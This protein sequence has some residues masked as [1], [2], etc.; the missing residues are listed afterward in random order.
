MQTVLQQRVDLIVFCGGDGTA[1]D[2]ATV[3]DKKIPLLGIPSGVKMHSGVFGVN[4]EAAGKMI[5]RFLSETVSVGD[6]EIMDLDE[7]LYRKGTWMVRLFHTVKGLIEPSFVQVG[8]MSFATVSEE[9]IKDDIAE[10]IKDELDDQPQTLFLFGSG[11]TID[12]IARFLGLENTVLGIDAVCNHQLVAKDM[13]EEK[14]LSL[15]AEYDQVKVL[16]S[17]IGAQGFILGRGNLQLSP[18]VIKKIGIEN[19]MVVST[20]AKL[21]STPV[22]RVDTGDTVLDE[23]FAHLEMIMVI[24]GYRVSRVV[25]I[26]Q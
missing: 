25:K 17:P 1:R 3:V 10:H 20:P 2:I 7:N 23:S 12:H 19:I 18:T 24:I 15:I 6:V 14:I 22:L 21:R 11:G 9:E 4:P 16:L 26:Q 8:K 13:N 5:H